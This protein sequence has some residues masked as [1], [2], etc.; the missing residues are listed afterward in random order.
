MYS[1]VKLEEN[2]KL[3]ESSPVSWHAITVESTEREI[4]TMR[5]YSLNLKKISRKISEFSFN[6]Q[7]DIQPNNIIYN[8]F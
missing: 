1:E 3:K 8:M 2:L 7:C 4:L 5:S 6:L